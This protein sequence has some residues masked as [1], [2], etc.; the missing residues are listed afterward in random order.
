[1]SRS[2]RSTDE[3]SITTQVTIVIPAHNEAQRIGPTLEQ[4]V[5]RFSKGTELLVVL[6]GC[7]DRTIDV[8]REY[9]RRFPEAVSFLDIPE[10]VGK[11]GAIRAGF[12]QAKGNLIGFV[13]ADGAT[14][15]D[16][17]ERIIASLDGYDGVVPSRWLPASTVYRR[18]SILRKVAGIGFRTITRFLFRLPYSDT[19]CGAK[20][21]TRSFVQAVAPRLKNRDMTFD[22]EMLLLARALGFRMR[23]IPTVWTDKSAPVLYGTPGKFLKTSVTMFLSLLRLRRRAVREHLL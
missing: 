16:E 10:A 18:T 1:M 5:R 13:D 21:F 3:R 4:Y 6:N 14:A 8:V 11:G 15:P 23:E 19:Q 9:S 12:M 20:I 7:T 22:V 17:F 2:R